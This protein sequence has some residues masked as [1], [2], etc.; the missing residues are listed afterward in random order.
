MSS[1]PIHSIASLPVAR[2]HPSALDHHRPPR[3]RGP[4]AAPA[5][6]PEGLAA[7]P[8]PRARPSS[9]D[10]PRVSAI[11]II[12]SQP[13]P[14]VHT[15]RGRSSSPLSAAPVGDASSQLEFRAAARAAAGAAPIMNAES[16]SR[17]TALHFRRRA[18][19]PAQAPWPAGE[20]DAGQA[21]PEATY[22]ECPDTSRD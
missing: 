18:R 8:G 22:S 19:A 15:V 14:P 5:G 12:L 17:G 10:S 4:P 7:G 2:W 20:E 16:P 11:G 13:G 9:R 6:S 1:K 21:A 3:R